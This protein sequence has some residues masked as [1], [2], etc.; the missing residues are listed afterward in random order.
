MNGVA[1]SP[2]RALVR[3][4]PR[5]LSAS[6]ASCAC[7]LGRTHAHAK[8]ARTD[9]GRSPRAIDSRERVGVPRSL[10]RIPHSGRSSSAERVRARLART[11]L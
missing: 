2:A 6:H 9:V 11:Y 10:A 1:I 8:T 4:N 7:V 3:A 5:R